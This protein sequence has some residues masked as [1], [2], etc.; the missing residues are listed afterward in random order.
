[1]APSLPSRWCTSVLTE[2]GKCT[3]NTQLG[4]VARYTTCVAA[5]RTGKA[6]WQGAS[7]ARAEEGTFQV[8][9]TP[10]AQAVRDEPGM[11][12]GPTGARCAWS[13]VSTR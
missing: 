8:E 12:A 2:A 3:L 7:H 4:D 13:V 9:R 5:C 10:A 6:E 11:T 1:M